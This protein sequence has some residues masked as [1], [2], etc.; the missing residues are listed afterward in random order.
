MAIFEFTFTDEST[1]RVNAPNAVD[2]RKH[3]D[4][5]LT[6]ATHTTQNAELKGKAVASATPTTIKP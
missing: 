2:A 3:V 5:L 4:T 1:I 6:L